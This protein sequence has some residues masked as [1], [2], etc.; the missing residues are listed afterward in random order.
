MSA[1]AIFQKGA[2]EHPRY[3][4]GIDAK[5]LDLEGLDG[6]SC[7]NGTYLAT[8]IVLLRLPICG[9]RRLT[10]KIKLERA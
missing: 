4:N 7:A 6:C 1:E 5:P 9:V 10:T 2:A 8:P 3:E